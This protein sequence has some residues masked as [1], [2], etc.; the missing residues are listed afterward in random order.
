MCVGMLAAANRTR[1]IGTAMIAAWRPQLGGAYT[2]SNGA[3]EKPQTTNTKP[4][5]EASENTPR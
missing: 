1:A 5:S 4:T 2:G 3:R